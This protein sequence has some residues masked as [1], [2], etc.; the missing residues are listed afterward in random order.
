MTNCANYC[1]I[2]TDSIKCSCFVEFEKCGCKSGGQ[3]YTSISIWSVH[4]PHVYPAVLTFYI[5][6]NV[7]MFSRIACAIHVLQKGYKEHYILYINCKQPYV[8]CKLRA[9]VLY[10]DDEVQGCSHDFSKGG[11]VSNPRYFPDC[12]V[13][14]PVVFLKCCIF[15]LDQQF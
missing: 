9:S 15:L 12:H 14:I 7:E 5:F 11:D 10:P 3:T 1:V 13:D 4:E 8:L 6:G 2:Q